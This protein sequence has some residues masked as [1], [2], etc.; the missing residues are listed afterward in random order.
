M[1]LRTLVVGLSLISIVLTQ[2]EQPKTATIDGNKSLDVENSQLNSGNNLTKDWSEYEKVRERI[3]ELRLS[4]DLYGLARLK[5]EVET[6]WGKTQPIDVFGR[7]LYAGLM[8]DICSGISS[9]NFDDNKQYMLSKKCVK[10]ALEKRDNMPVEQ[11]VSLVPFL[12]I[13]KHYIRAFTDEQMQKNRKQKAEYW[14]HSWQRLENE[15][16]KNYNVQDNRPKKI[17]NLSP[18]EKAKAETYSKQYKLH[19]LRTTYIKQFKDFVVET[20]STPPYNNTE[21][22]SFLNKYVTDAK[23]KNSIL[24]E[25]EKKIE[26]RNSQNKQ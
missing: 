25:V 20:Y 14:F 26:E 13:P 23:L 7:N 24:A 4:K 12:I 9:Y 17:S 21:F 16:N 6:S 22:E 15:I 3:R 11:E 5:D 2:N 8:Y 1:F 18:E 10:Q 19:N